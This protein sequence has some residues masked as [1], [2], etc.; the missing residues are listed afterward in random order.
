MPD[1]K[2]WQFKQVRFRVHDRVADS[3]AIAMTCIA[4][5]LSDPAIGVAKWIGQSSHAASELI[6][7]LRVT[8]I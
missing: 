8:R 6:F 2:P 1:S 5:Y 7:Q 4:R 3:T